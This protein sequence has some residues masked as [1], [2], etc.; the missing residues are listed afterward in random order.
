[1]TA[2]YSP[3]KTAVELMINCQSARFCVNYLL[4]LILPTPYRNAEK[5]AKA[6]SSSGGDDLEA[7]MASLRSGGGLDKASLAKLKAKLAELKGEAR[8]VHRLV[9]IA[10]PTPMPAM[11]KKSEEGGGAGADKAKSRFSGQTIHFV[12]KIAN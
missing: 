3:I 1:M 8:R 12:C 7:Y 11:A 4:N 2:E 5:A 6:N 9:E 10:R